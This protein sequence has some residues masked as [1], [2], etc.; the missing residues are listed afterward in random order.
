[1]YADNV[2]WG[3]E[4]GGPVGLLFNGVGEDPQRVGANVLG[5]GQHNVT[6]AGLWLFRALGQSILRGP[7]THTARNPRI[8]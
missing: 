5:I 4:S 6:R 7:I 8:H 3:D 2:V 1:M